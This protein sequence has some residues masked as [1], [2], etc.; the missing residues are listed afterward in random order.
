M[1][2]AFHKMEAPPREMQAQPQDDHEVGTDDDEIELPGEAI[3]EG[4]V[5]MTPISSYKLKFTLNGVTQTRTIVG[6][7]TTISGMQFVRIDGTPVTSFVQYLAGCGYNRRGFAKLPAVKATQEARNK[8]SMTKA[9]GWDVGCRRAASPSM[10]IYK[11]MMESGELVGIS[12]Q[13]LSINVREVTLR[14]L[15][16]SHTDAEPLWLCVSDVF[17]F[18]KLCKELGTAEP[19]EK[20]PSGIRKRKGKG[21]IVYQ[22]KKFRDGKETFSTYN[23]LEEAMQAHAME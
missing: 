10:F 23:S 2:P 22:V 17:L 12:D 18:A 3:P 21:K 8:A 11:K 14:V 16:R 6:E 4:G 20:L 1:I 7:H 13:F 19:E 5:V 9:C 15:P